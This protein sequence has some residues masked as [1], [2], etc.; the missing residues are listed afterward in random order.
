MLTHQPNLDMDIVQQ[1]AKGLGLAFVPE[2]EPT[3]TNP[4]RISKREGDPETF[5]P[6]DLLD[7]I[8]AV[9][10]SPSYRER[11]TRSF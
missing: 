5:A 10:H 9:Q 3:F 2:P 4:Q 8:Y 7:Y 6:I 11:G 1:I